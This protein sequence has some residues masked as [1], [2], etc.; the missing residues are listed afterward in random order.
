VPSWDAIGWRQVEAEVVRLRRRI[1]AAERAGDHARVISLQR[2]M[3]RSRAN[4]LVSVRRVTEHNAGR[5]TAGIDG[6]L[7]LTSSDKAELADR[8]QRSSAPWR[9]RPVKRV[10]IP[11]S[12]KKLR[13]LGIPTIA[14]R[15][16]QNRVRNALEPQWEARFEARSYGF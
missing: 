8:L 2:L 11:K 1:Y 16:Q 9:A 6:K 7:A 15:A 10:Y 3:L 13:P 12:N 14:D 5:A 4:T